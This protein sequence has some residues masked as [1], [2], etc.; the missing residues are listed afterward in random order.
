MGR[1]FPS[2]CRSASH[3]TPEGRQFVGILRDLRPRWAVEM[4]LNQLQADLVH[5]A[6][7]SAM[8]EMGAALAHE[9]NQ[10]LTAVMLYLQAFKRAQRGQSG[11]R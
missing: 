9:L 11:R 3:T 6:R 8:D 10:P 5:M 1:F 2:S 4:R 7:V